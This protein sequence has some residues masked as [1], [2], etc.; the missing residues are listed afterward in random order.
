VGRARLVEV[1]ESN[2]AAGEEALPG[3]S[4][5]GDSPPPAICRNYVK[6]GNL[7]RVQHGRTKGPIV[8]EPRK[9][10]ASIFVSPFFAPAPVAPE[11]RAETE[12][13]VPIPNLNGSECRRGVQLVV[14]DD[15]DE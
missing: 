7:C 1:G 4:D 10:A 5:T 2:I 13:G 14:K 15:A 9:L 12:S 11:N 6:V 8:C 3:S